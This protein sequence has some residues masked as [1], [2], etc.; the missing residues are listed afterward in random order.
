MSPEP[1]DTNTK[2]TTMSTQTK[3]KITT[4]TPADI[5]IEEAI[6]IDS[7]EEK[8]LVRRLDLFIIP[9]VMA[10]YTFSFLDRVNIGN[11]KLY[12]LESDLHLSASQ[13]QLS[14]SLLFIPYLLSELPSNLVLKRLRPSRWI[15]FIATSWGIIATLT[16][17]VYSFGGLLT[18]R[19]LLGVVEG[20]LFPGMTIYLTFFYT[21]RELALRIGYLFV[22]SALA[23]AFGGLLSYAIAHMDGLCGL[24][25]WRWIMIL[26]GLPSIL[27]GITCLLYLPD[28]PTTAHFL[29]PRQKTILTTRLANQ[30]HVT[31]TSTQLHRRDVMKGLRDWKVWMF[32]LAQFGCDTMLYGYSTFLPTI[33][34]SLGTWSTTESQALTIPCYALGAITYMATAHLSDRSQRRC[35]YTVSFGC[36]SLLG[37][38]LLLTPTSSGV[39]YLGCFLIAMGLYTLVGLPL[40]WLPS[41]Q[42]RYG[43]KT[44]ATALQLM[45][46]N[47]SGILAGFLYPE[48]EGPRFI[49][50]Q[51]VSL[52]MVAWAVFVYAGMGGYFRWRNARRAGG[53][54][55]G[56]IEGLSP[57]ERR[58]LGDEDPGFVFMV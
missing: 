50:G 4:T 1:L 58:E 13:Y 2:P 21:S 42:P 18:C 25:A 39:H 54:E 30:Q 8:K 55:D 20:G 17:I 11:A 28:S 49:R 47:A 41:N 45:G 16:G 31:P 32:A 15:A 9:L 3:T 35:I 26:Q 46:G 14:V 5:D 24:R 27:L 10:L 57:E 48:A 51:A 40:A 37:Y 53:K 22:S 43:K 36:I 23:G 7:R 29:T 44:T 38:A 56:K 34:K 19:L 52:G 33:I 6:S 12:G